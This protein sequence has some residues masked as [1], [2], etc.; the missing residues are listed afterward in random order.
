MKKAIAI[1]ILPALLLSSAS[2][3]GCKNKKVNNEQ[4]KVEVQAVDTIKKN[5]NGNGNIL[6]PFNSDEDLENI[7]NLFNL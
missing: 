6:I 3:T 5:N 7:I 4:K 2:L 1:L